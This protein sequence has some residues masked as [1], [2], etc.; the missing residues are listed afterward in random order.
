MTRAEGRSLRVHLLTVARVDL[1]GFGMSMSGSTSVADLAARADQLTATFLRMAWT[2][3]ATTL[4]EYLRAQA[5]ITSFCEGRAAEAFAGCDLIACPT[6][7][8]PPFSRDLDW[9][10]AEVAGEPID[11]FLGWAFTWPFNLTGEPAVSLPCAW[12]D[13]GLPIG[14]QLVGPRGHDGLVLRAA[15]AIE[16][17]TPR[18]RLSY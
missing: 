9:G 13:D 14:L 8:V 11:P 4:A 5:A 17:L 1:L 16:A 12:T 7:A 3:T 18:E 15:A 2:G 6:L 10:P